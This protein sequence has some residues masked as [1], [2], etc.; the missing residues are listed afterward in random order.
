MRIR[1]TF[2]AADDLE[3]IKN[4]LQQNYP[5]FAEPTDPDNLSAHPPAEDLTEPRQTRPPERHKRTGAHAAPLRRGLPCASGR[6]RNPAHLSR[7]AGLA[8]RIAATR[9]PIQSRSLPIDPRFKGAPVTT[10]R[11]VLGD[12]LALSTGCRLITSVT[13]GSRQ[14]LRARN[15]AINFLHGAF[16]TIPIHVSRV[17]HTH[18]RTDDSERLAFIEGHGCLSATTPGVTTP[19]F[20]AYGGF[21]AYWSCS[22]SAC[23]SCLRSANGRR[24]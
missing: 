17:L 24:P 9:C 6:R 2:P 20:L 1:W 15:A 3:N 21:S 11:A 22:Y 16:Q 4:Y 5:Q 12:P 23:H 18:L 8:Q 10:S 19:S 14:D 7:R 13:S